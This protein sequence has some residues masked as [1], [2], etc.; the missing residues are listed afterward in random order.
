MRLV[1]TALRQTL[2]SGWARLRRGLRRRRA[3]PFVQQVEAADC[4]PA[5]LA[6]VLGFFGR[7]TSLREVRDLVGAAR[8]VSAR[9]L[10]EGGRALGLRGRG[11]QIDLHDLALLPRGAVLHWGFD[12]FVVFDRVER[13]FGLRVV[14]PSLGPRSVPPA[15]VREKF[16]GVALL[17]EP[18]ETFAPRQEKRAPLRAYLARMAAHRALLAR[19]VVLSLVVQVLALGL[20][21]LLGL[22][23]D[24]VVPHRDHDLLV[25]LGAGLL[26]LVVFHG[27]TLLLRSVLLDYLKAALDAQLS[28]GFVDHLAQLPYAFFVQRS[29]GDLLARFESNR[30]LRQTLTGFTLSTVLDGGFVLGYLALLMAGSPV[31]GLLVLGLGLLQVLMFVA[32]RRRTR[33]LAALELEVR[34]RAQ[35]QLVEILAGI[36]TLKSLGAE[37]HAVERWSHAFVE[38]LNVG[39][40]R[41]KL[42]S[43]AGALTSAL[44]LAA[45]LCILLVGAWQVLHGQLSLGSMLALN[46]LAAGFLGPLSSLIVVALHM[47]EARGHIERIEDV[48]GA[49]PEQPATS[50]RPMPRLRGGIVLE[51]VGFRYGP[52][53]PWALHDVSLE[54]RPGE[55]LAIVGRSGAGKSTLARLLVGL[56]RPTTG[57]IL[58]DGADAAGLDLDRLRAQVGVVTQDA[59]L[60]ALSVRDNLGLAAPEA[61]QEQLEDAARRAQVLDELLALPMGLE[62]PLADGAASLSGGQRQRLALARALARDPA[63]LLLDE[64]TSDLDTLAEA[65][66]STELDALGCTRISIAHRLSTVIRADR[67][68]VLEGGRVVEVGSHAELLAAGGTYTQL[69]A[70]QVTPAGHIDRSDGAPLT[71]VAPPS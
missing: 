47:Q 31:V 39:L 1:P 44:T 22:L 56:Y 45:P 28:L 17:F 64:A 7:D 26:A 66:V 16:T 37:K 62:T 20:P 35:A 9:S 53:D 3:I 23:V 52:R 41:A 10:I 50:A 59:R 12:H 11:V 46:A 51:R 14:D 69:V 40:A 6:M 48:L 24:R 68:V 15:L 30:D 8:G 27:L 32:F 43:L 38:E 71:I 19:A 70:A 55:H 49:P 21:L 42:G 65:R 61:S 18:S 57:R 54:V 60:F 5:C 4:G 36:E 29:S 63:I 67:I 2:A 58:F 33:D 13:E 25:L 34:G